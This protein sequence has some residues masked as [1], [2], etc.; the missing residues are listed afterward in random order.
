MDKGNIFY[1]FFK[2]AVEVASVIFISSPFGTLSC[3]NGKK[4]WQ[5]QVRLVFTGQRGCNE[6]VHGRGI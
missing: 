3:F 1:D 6:K 5:K 2:F 4:Q